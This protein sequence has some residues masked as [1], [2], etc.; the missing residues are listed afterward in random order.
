MVNKIKKIESKNFGENIKE[1]PKKIIYHVLSR[2]QREGIH[3]CLKDEQR[4]QTKKTNKFVSFVKK[5]LSKFSNWAKSKVGKKVLI[6][7]LVFALIFVGVMIYSSLTKKSLSN[8]FESQV[9]VLYFEDGQQSG[10][11]KSDVYNISVFEGNKV[12]TNYTH[13]YSSIEFTAKERA[14]TSCDLHQLYFV[15]YP[16]ASG[17]MS[18]K[19]TFKDKS[20]VQDYVYEQSLLCTAKTALVFRIPLNLSFNSTSHETK[21]QFTF[22]YKQEGISFSLLQMQFI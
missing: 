17:E 2:K 9:S 22:A 12:Q 19:L 6:I 5:Y 18:F 10:V 16:V 14:N 21:M 13:L 15:L 3:D 11:G 7:L 4:V 1:E 8:F 20:F